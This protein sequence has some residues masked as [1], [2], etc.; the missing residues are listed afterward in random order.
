MIAPALTG[1]LKP[2]APPRKTLAEMASAANLPTTSKA[3]KVIENAVTVYLEDNPEGVQRFRNGDVSV[4]KDAFKEFD[5]DFLSKLK[6]ESAATLVDTKTAAQ[7]LPP[8]LRSGSPP[9]PSAP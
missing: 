4:L 9:C 3:L 5:T 2:G 1:L 7:R 8:A 6:R